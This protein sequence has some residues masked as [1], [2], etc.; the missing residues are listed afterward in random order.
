MRLSLLSSL[1]LSAA[2]LPALAQAPDPAGYPTVDRVLYVQECM[3]QHPGPFFEMINKCGCT[4]DTIAREVTYDDFTTMSTIANAMT[5]GGERGST[6]RDNESL[7]PQ[8][9]RFRELQTKAKRSC[10]INPDA[11]APAR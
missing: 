8:I 3:R 1:L 2:A 6:M 4:I 5:I 10:F 11:P 9:K 7:Q